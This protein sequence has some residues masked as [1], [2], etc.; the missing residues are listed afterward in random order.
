MQHSRP[1]QQQQGSSP[2]RSSRSACAARSAS[3]TCAA[4]RRP[5]AGR[6][7]SACQTTIRRVT[8]QNRMS[9]TSIMRSQ[10]ASQAY[11]NMQCACRCILIK[12]CIQRAVKNTPKIRIRMQEIQKQVHLTWNMG[13]VRKT[14]SFTL[15]TGCAPATANGGIV[16]LALTNA[17]RR[18]T[19]S[20]GQLCKVNACQKQFCLQ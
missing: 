17:L 13:L 12:H 7:A 9:K 6:G 14:V 20:K 18:H 1:T 8:G 4:R 3:P 15:F 2:P 5:K 16:C 19:K 11:R 10:C